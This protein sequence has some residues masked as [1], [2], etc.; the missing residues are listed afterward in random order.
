MVMTLYTI[1]DTN[2]SDELQQR[3]EYDLLAQKVGLWD[4]TSF[5]KNLKLLSEFN[6]E[7]KDKFKDIIEMSTTYK[8]IE[9]KLDYNNW[10]REMWNIY[11]CMSSMYISA[12]YNRMC[13]EQDVKPEETIEV[14]EI[15]KKAYSLYTEDYD[16]F[17]K[18]VKDVITVKGR[19][20]WAFKN[21]PKKKFGT[22]SDHE[23]DLIDISKIPKVPDVPK[24]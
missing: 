12:L 11:D 6:E 21:K 17:I 8:E 20:E 1:T 16:T 7:Y 23:I 10:F 19:N 3:T 4:K 9:S 5:L 22:S 15:Y 18:V 13:A 2:Q 14:D 24:G